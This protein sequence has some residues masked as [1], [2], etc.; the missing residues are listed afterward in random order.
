MKQAALVIKGSRYFKATEIIQTLGISRQTLWRWRQDGRIPL[1]SKY[2]DRV[3]IFTEQEAEQI[4]E[5]ADRVVPAAI[6]PSIP[7]ARSRT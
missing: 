4:R 5:F 3:L 2:K 1:G 6:S 7:R